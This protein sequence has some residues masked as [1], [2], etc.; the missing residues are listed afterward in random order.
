MKE[1]TNLEINVKKLEF[2][3][4]YNNHIM[5][6]PNGDKV[7]PCS[8]F[9]KYKLEDNEKLECV[10]PETVGIF[11]EELSMKTQMLN[12]QHENVRNDLME[13]KGKIIIN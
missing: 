12:I 1:E 9:F 3:G 11:C 7:K 2:F 13:N 4:V 6:Y 8:F 5:E 10:E